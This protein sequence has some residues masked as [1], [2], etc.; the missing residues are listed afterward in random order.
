MLRFIAKR[1]GLGLATLWLVGVVVFF[2]THSLTGNIAR[3]ILGPFAPEEAITK[4]NADLGTDRPILLQYFE[5]FGGVLK[6]DLGSSYAFR[7]PVTDLLGPA[8]LNSA[9]L[10]LVAFAIVVPL[11]IFGGVIAALNEGKLVDRIVSIGGL[12]ATV[13]PEFVWAVVVIMLLGL[14][15]DLLP[16]SARSP[17][18]AGVLTQIEH[19]LLPAFCVV[20]QLFGYIARMTR[21][22][23]VEALHA[24]YTRTAVLKGLPRRTVIMRH[25]LRNSLLPTIAVIATQTAYM[26]GSFVAIELIFNYPGVGQLIFRAAKQTDFP[27]LVS[28][29]FIVAVLFVIFSLAA[30]LLYSLLNP[31]IRLAGT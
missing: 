10:A 25:V 18:G 8:L 19:L 6:G 27:L 15:L 23:T 5:W 17:R 13:I 14:W 31:R 9:K 16:V 1:V 22:G 7:Q 20:L 4:L 2:G 3:R 12:T 29:V 24:D 11:S 28:A 26:L 30:D 21:A